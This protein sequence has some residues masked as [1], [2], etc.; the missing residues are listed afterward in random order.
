MKKNYRSILT[1]AFSTNGKL[2]AAI[3][4]FFLV[5]Y[6]L[7]AQVS[8]TWDSNTTNGAGYANK[9]NGVIQLTDG[10]PDGK[11]SS[12][13]RE[14]TS[15]ISSGGDFSR[16]Y[17][18]FFG[19]VKSDNIGSDASGDGMAFTLYNPS[20]CTFNENGN[21]GGGGLGYM[22]NCSGQKTLTIE[23]DTYSSQGNASFDGFYG[24]GTSGNN[25]EIALHIDGN[26][27][28][29][30]R[31]GTPSES[32]AGNLDDGN[33]H[34][35]CISYKFSTKT[36]TVAIDGVT[37]FTSVYDIS[38]YFGG[39]TNLAQAWSAGQEGATNITMVND[40]GAQGIFS[41]IGG[42]PCP[43]PSCNKTNTAPV[44]D[45]AA[46]IDAIWNAYPWTS[47]N[48]FT[49]TGTVS[50]TNLSARYKVMFDNTNVYVLIDVTDDNV[51]SSYPGG[52]A[53]YNK[54][55]VELYMDLGDKKNGAYLATDYQF[56]MVYGENQVREGAHNSGN[57]VTS[58]STISFGET[59]TGTGY[60]M[61]VAIPWASLGSAGPSGSFLG[62]DVGVNDD[63]NGTTR[64]NQASANDSGHPPTEWNDTK[65]FGDLSLSSCTLPISLLSFTGKLENNVTVL[66]WITA[67]EIDN[68][69]FLVERSSNG[70]DWEVIGTIAGAGNSTTLNTY[71]Y[72][73]YAPFNGVTYYR[74]VQIDYNGQSSTS[75]V[76]VVQTG[77]EGVVIGPNPFDESFTIRTLTKGTLDI[78]IYD[79]V[80]K[81]VYHA[82]KNV[83]DGSVTVHPE[84]ASGAYV[85][86][87]Q[88]GEY[89]EHQRIVKR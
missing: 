8:G 53:N 12:A 78:S 49:W 10:N 58:P 31:A 52:T 6:N 45:A 80:G 19:C 63:D 35:V 21:A 20:T 55:G 41:Q 89:Q 39:T 79:V 62:F 60:R 70:K 13:V 56:I 54:D 18:V 17:Q 24:G 83:E 3:F 30:G 84:L 23:F 44:I 29:A 67:T 26:A 15:L 66:N 72:T 38:S 48:N 16:C 81:L 76:V 36:I 73:D 37:K 2:L 71:T 34:Q 9:G 69:E 77:R 46:N 4:L 87:I 28:D 85:V 75:N 7:D 51:I 40:G 64:A 1:K 61:E 11:V 42:T 27:Q 32:N 86:T 50:V 43:V 22:D 14:T 25:D 68:K 47:L 33:E 65:K 59:S 57:V 5:N 74:L 82:A 88:S